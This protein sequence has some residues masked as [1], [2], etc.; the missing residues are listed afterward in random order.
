MSGFEHSMANNLLKPG[1][2]NLD[3][4]ELLLFLRGQLEAFGQFEE[5]DDNTVYLPG[6]RASCEIAVTVKAPKVVRIRPGA[7]FDSAKWDKIAAEIDNTLIA[8]T[9][10]V[11]REYSFS[12]HRVNSWWR[13]NRSGVQILPPPAG[14]CAD[15]S[16]RGG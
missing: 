7:A 16:G 13:G 6:G 12:G 3:A 1:W 4:D 8:H 14:R 10:Q 2:G 5:N 9:A 11:G 15:R